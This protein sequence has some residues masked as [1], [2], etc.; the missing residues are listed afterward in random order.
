MELTN[1]DDLMRMHGNDE[2]VRLE[3]AGKFADYLYAAVTDVV[4]SKR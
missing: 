3:D 1:C 4:A 2:R